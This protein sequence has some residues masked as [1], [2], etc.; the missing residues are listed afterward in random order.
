[1]DVALFE[2]YDKDEL[3]WEELKKSEVFTVD[4]E[5]EGPD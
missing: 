2:A 5:A 4:P 3:D 1:M